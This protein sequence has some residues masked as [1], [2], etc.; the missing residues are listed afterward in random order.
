MID[1]IVESIRSEFHVRSQ[2]GIAKYGTTLA[3]NQAELVGRIQHLKEELMD[4]CLYAEWILQKLK[5]YA[6]DGK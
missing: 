4:G 2:L 1:P 3:G 6:D 5:S